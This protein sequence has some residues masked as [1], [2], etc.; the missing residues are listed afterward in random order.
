MD[1]LKFWA[2]RQPEA[3]KTSRTRLNRKKFQALVESRMTA[4]GNCVY[5]QWP[6]KVA[7]LRDVPRVQNKVTLVQ[8]T[9]LHSDLWVDP[10]SI[11]DIVLAYPPVFSLTPREK[12][13]RLLGPH[14]RDRLVVEES[15]GTEEDCLRQSKMFSP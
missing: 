7:R 5:A 3:L 12:I 13:L 8:A 1:G 14:Q 10:G 11:L 9:S 15:R 4:S 2:D 6:R